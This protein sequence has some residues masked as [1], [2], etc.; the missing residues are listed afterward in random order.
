MFVVDKIYGMASSWRRHIS[1]M[2]KFIQS[3]SKRQLNSCM[4]YLCLVNKALVSLSLH[5]SDVANWYDLK[6]L[7]RSRTDLLVHYVSDFFSL[8]T[9]FY[10]GETYGSSSWIANISRCLFN[11]VFIKISKYS[12][13]QVCEW[14]Q[15]GILSLQWD[16]HWDRIE[17]YPEILLGASPYYREVIYKKITCPYYLQGTEIGL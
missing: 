4:F 9:R 11:Y 12:P 5:W 15:I 17:P 10:Y 8:R 1:V 2:K 6:V 13:T 3:I 14:S 7:T 16:Y